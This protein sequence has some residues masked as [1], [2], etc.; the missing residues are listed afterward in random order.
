MGR[1]AG[2]LLADYIARMLDWRRRRGKRS[3]TPAETLPDKHRD[4]FHGGERALLYLVVEEFL[5]N[6]GMDGRACLLR[7]IC[8]IHANPRMANFGLFGEMIKLFF[9]YVFYYY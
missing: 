1:A 3:A 6:F 8:E 5:E 7:A 4:A 2:S 9:T